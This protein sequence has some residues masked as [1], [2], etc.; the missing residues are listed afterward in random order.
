MLSDLGLGLDEAVETRDVPYEPSPFSTKK[1]MYSGKGGAQVTTL[2][3]SNS[4]YTL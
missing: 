4:V 1:D 3:Y 2:Q